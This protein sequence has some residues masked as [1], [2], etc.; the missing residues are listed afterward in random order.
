MSLPESTDR[1]RAL[2]PP[3]W[4]IYTTML[5]VALLAILIAIICLLAELAR[6]N[7]DYQATG[8]QLRTAQATVSRLVEVFLA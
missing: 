3:K 8:A 1:T 4:D 7:W 2:S 5:A 6:Y